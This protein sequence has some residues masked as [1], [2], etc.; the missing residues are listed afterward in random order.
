MD[1]KNNNEQRSVQHEIICPYCLAPLT[2]KDIVFFSDDPNDQG[3]EKDEVHAEFM[4]SV[5]RNYDGTRSFRKKV[6]KTT[7]TSDGL[8]YPASWPEIIDGQS[9]PNPNRACAHC[10]NLIPRDRE[11]TRLNSSH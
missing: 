6:I 10:H 11:S 1:K 5:E 3:T 2:A 9:I 8:D 4:R 7:I